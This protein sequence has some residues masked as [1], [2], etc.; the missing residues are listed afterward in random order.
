MCQL[1]NAQQRHLNQEKKRRKN[2]LLSFIYFLGDNEMVKEIFAKTILNRHKKRDPWFLDDYSLNPYQL[3]EFNCV[4]CYIRGS[5][6]GDMKRELAVKINAPAILERELF[7]R[8]ERK[9]YGFIALSSATEPWMY[10]EEKHEI[11]RKCLEI[12]S[13]HNFPVHCLT[14]SSL[15]LRDIDILKEIDENAVLPAD[16]RGKLNNG[17]LITFSFSTLDENVRKIFEPNAPKVKERLDTVKELK[18][19]GLKVGIAFIPLLPFI[20]DSEERIEEMVKAAKELNV[21]YVFFGDLTLYGKGKEIYFKVLE[22]YFPE[23]VEEYEKIY[24]G[25]Y[26]I[27]SYRNA[28]YKLAFELCKKYG[29]KWRIV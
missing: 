19:L 23:L 24:R 14:K 3:C 2:D 29:I 28:F 26:L 15:I 10:I 22:R 17:V 5:K 13:K 20:S 7:R 12:I 8:A 21:N 9:E 25:A 1:R 16:L 11:T 6:Y 18:D 4:Y 27:R